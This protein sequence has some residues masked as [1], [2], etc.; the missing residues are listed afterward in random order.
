[1]ELTWRIF[2]SSGDPITGGAASTEIKLRRVADGY[3]FDWNDST[4]KA[5]GWTTLGATMTEVDATNLAGAYKKTVTES[6]FNDGWYEIFTRYTGTPKIAG[7]MSFL[8][9]GG[10]VIETHVADNLDTTVSSR[11]ASTTRISPK[12]NTALSNFE[13]LMI[14]NTDHLTPKTGLTVAAQ[15]SID[16]AAFG[17]CANSVSELASG[18]Y[19][20]NFANTDLNGDVITFKFTATGADPNYITIVTQG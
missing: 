10:K 16:G 4:F 13:F 2:N 19:K 18:I 1:M 17:N 9:E 5:S 20:I 12:K 8:I 14:D 3:L 7:E 11:L 15:R 6:G